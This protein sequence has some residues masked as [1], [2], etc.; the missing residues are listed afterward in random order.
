MTE[1]WLKAQIEAK[2][3]TP[4]RLARKTGSS[5]GWMARIVRGVGHP[6]PSLCKKIASALDMT[7]HEVLRQY[8]YLSSLPDDYQE[9]EEQRFIEAIRQ[10]PEKD[11]N[12]LSDFVDF[13]LWRDGEGGDD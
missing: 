12:L 8:G 5:S 11:R 9:A 10:L 2:D 7:E 13:L 6:S 4:S 1:T 3:L